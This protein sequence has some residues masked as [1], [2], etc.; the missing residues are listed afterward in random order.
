VIVVF[1]SGIWISS[2]LFGGTPRFALVRGVEI[3]RIAICSRVE[4]EIVDIL[5]RKFRKEPAAIGDLLQPF[6]RDA[7][8]IEITGEVAGACRDP[9]DD[10]VL[11]CAWKAG[12]ELI[13]TGDKDLLTLGEFRGIRILTARQ[14]LDLLREPGTPSQ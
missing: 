2:F 9:K 6:L 12:A 3:D 5:E 8:R 7:V 13:V 1:D 10:F 11:E 14:Y 4:A